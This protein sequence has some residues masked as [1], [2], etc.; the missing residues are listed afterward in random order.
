M[1]RAQRLL[2]DDV[3][4]G[5]LH[6]DDER[7]RRRPVELVAQSARGRRGCPRRGR[8]RRRAPSRDARRCGRA[9]PRG[10]VPKYATRRPATGA[11]G[12]G[13]SVVAIDRHARP[14]TSSETPRRA[15]RARRPSSAIVTTT[16]SASSAGTRSGTRSPLPDPGA[17][18][19]TRTRRSAAI[20]GSAAPLPSKHDQVRAERRRERGRPRARS[21]C[22][23]RPASP[24][25][26][27]RQPTVGTPAS[28]AVSRW[29]DAAW[30]PARE[31]ASRSSTVGGDLDDLRLG[32]PAPPHRDDDDAPVAREQ[33]R[34]VPRDGRLADPLARADHGDRRQRERLEARRVEAEVGA[35]VRHARARAPGSRART[36][37]PARA[38]A[39]RRD[40]RPRP[41]RARR[42]PP[43]AT[44]RAARRSPRRRAASRSPPTSTAATISYGSSASASRTTAA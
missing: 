12:R 9:A 15:A 36:A 40:R 32:R 26:Q 24:P 44:P 3:D 34:H 16:R 41:A 31:S 37:R 14:R 2:G 7:R 13:R 29:S 21:R 43:R 22:R 8:P 4:R 23:R 6:L 18:P 17:H 11:S 5:G 20:G 19:T 38:R 35:L 30:R 33:P 1:P 42:P 27:R 39:R 28:A 25:P 10:A